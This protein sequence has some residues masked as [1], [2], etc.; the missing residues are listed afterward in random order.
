MAKILNMK[1]KHQNHL[2]YV[3]CRL[4]K[5]HIVYHFNMNVNMIMIKYSLLIVFHMN[6]VD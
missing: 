6:T 1:R 5:N 3:K 2:K 4:T